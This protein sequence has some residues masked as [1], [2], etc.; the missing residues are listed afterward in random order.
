VIVAHPDDETLWAGGTILSHPSWK[1]FILCL[2]R[3]SD[4]ERASKF[5]QAL[6]ILHSDGSM[7]DLDDGP[8]Q[9]PLDE[10]DV[11]KAILELLPCKHYDLILTHNISGEYTHHLRHQE[12]SK[13]VTNLWLDN[14]ISADSLLT[15][16]YED[17]NKL[18]LPRA[19]ENATIFK[20]LSK[21]IWT[22]KYNLITKIYGFENQSWEARTTPL[23]EAFW[24]SEPILTPKRQYLF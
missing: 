2:C 14:E 10:P 3:G 13:A 23:A 11:R 17:G 20:P 8:Q 5:Y 1:W 12:V 15:F 9:K 19:I 4:I 18:Y 21:K 7:G 16:A 6:Q 22:K 24:E